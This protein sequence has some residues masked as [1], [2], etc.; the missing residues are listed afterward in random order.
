MCS[1]LFLSPPQC[2]IPN[3]AQHPG[4]CLKMA[5]SGPTITL[6][7]QVLS[8]CC[9]ILW[10]PRVTSCHSCWDSININIYKCATIFDAIILLTVLPYKARRC[11]TQVQW[12]KNWKVEALDPTYPSCTLWLWL[13]L[14][15]KDEAEEQEK[16]S[17][18]TAA[19]GHFLVDQGP[20]KGWNEN[21]VQEE[22]GKS[23]T[24]A[25]SYQPECSLGLFLLSFS[26]YMKF[27][28]NQIKVLLS[29]STHN[30]FELLGNTVSPLCF[31]RN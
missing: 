1:D 3:P 31:L 11:P 19:P 10:K 22:P 14:L 27:I 12:R 25:G 21:C 4:C 2:G 15:H 13:F 18:N 5:S 9:L 20:L 30:A 23:W 16:P 6:Q 24:S 8:H 28:R 26:R 29:K 17:E 7:L